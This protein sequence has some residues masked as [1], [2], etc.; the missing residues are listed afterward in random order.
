MEE[1]RCT[2]QAV[3][4]R[5]VKT[6]GSATSGESPRREMNQSAEGVPR[7][8]GMQLELFERGEGKTAFDFR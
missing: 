2:N 6:P 4:F 8:R 1:T 7:E 3:G 5:R